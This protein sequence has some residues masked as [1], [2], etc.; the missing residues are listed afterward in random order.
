MARHRV[1]GISFDHMHMGDLLRQVAEHPDAEI[2]GIFDPDRARMAAAIAT[3][4]IPED[5]VFTDLD[6]CLA[7][8]R[9]TSPSSA[10]R[11]REHAE[12]VEAIAPHGINVMVEKPFAASAAD[13]RRMIAAMEG[14]RRGSRSTG[15]SPGIRRTTPPSGWSTRA[16]SAS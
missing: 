5:R 8:R 2:A 12:T 3:F 1:L 15:R 14:T 7:G 16:R 4:G 6:A 13:A 11:R 10:R 9:P